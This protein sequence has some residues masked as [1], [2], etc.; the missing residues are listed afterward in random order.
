MTN[1]MEIQMTNQMTTKTIIKITTPDESSNDNMYS[2][3]DGN[4]FYNP[5]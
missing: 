2:T 3:V 4:P 5:D 1:Q